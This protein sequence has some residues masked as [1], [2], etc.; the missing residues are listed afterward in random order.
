MINSRFSIL[1]DII[2]SNT[3]KRISYEYILKNAK[4]YFS[5]LHS[6]NVVKF[7]NRLR[8]RG[9]EIAHFVIDVRQLPNLCNIGNTLNDFLR[10]Q[11]LF[12]IQSR[13]FNKNCWIVK[14]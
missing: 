13:K 14:T 8:K 7:Q 6:A 3:L 4:E 9:E 11:R 10:D 5:P 1:R 12:G 2:E